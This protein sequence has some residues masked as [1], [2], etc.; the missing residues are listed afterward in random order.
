MR[1]RRLIGLVLVGT[2]LLVGCRPTVDQGIDG[3][4]QAA[5]APAIARS[6]TLDT[7]ARATTQRMCTARKATSTTD[8]TAV[9]GREPAAAIVERVTAVAVDSKVAAAKQVEDASQRV[10]ASWG[11]DPVWA[12]PRWDDLG[13]AT[14]RCAD[15]RVYVAAVLRDRPDTTT[16]YLVEELAAEKGTKRYIVDRASF[17]AATPIVDGWGDRSSAI[18]DDR[19]VSVAVRVQRIWDATT[20]SE[21]NAIAR[22]G[23]SL[24]PTGDLTTPWTDI[25]TASTPAVLRQVAERMRA[26]RAAGSTPPDRFAYWIVFLTF[27]GS[28]STDRAV[29]ACA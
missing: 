5:A 7:A 24:A 27:I 22:L 17:C 1:A 12:E 28:Y 13:L 14:L 20:A 9:Y 25:Q 6:T 3:A 2:G 15:G 19:T 10:W 4:R 23:A 16:P 18:F 29:T 11:S 8:R 26:A 21:I